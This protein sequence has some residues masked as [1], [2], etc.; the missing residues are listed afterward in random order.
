M[1]MANSRIAQ[2]PQLLKLI[3]AASLMFL[4]S[5]WLY[6]DGLAVAVLRWERQ[7]EYSHGYL[8]PLISLYF[9]WEA[10]YKILST[11]EKPSWLG[12]PIIVLALV[13][14]FV[15][16]VS[17]LFI[18]IHYSFI[19][20]LLGG[21]LALLGHAAK[22]TVLP[23][24]FLCFAIPLPYFLEVIL[25]AK[26]QLIS[27]ELGVMIIR[28]FSIPVF[29]SGNIIDLGVYK[30]QVVEA[31]S[32]LRY[33]F[34]LMSLSFMAAYFYRVRF[35][36]R[37]LLF[38]S[39]VPVTVVMNSVRIAITG[40]L[41]DQFGIEMAEGFLHDFE[42]WIIF[43]ACGGILVC[44]V[45]ILEML[46]SK[47]S[48][49]EVFAPEVEISEPSSAWYS[50]AGLRLAPILTG[51]V[52]VLVALGTI[53]QVDNRA[54]TPPAARSLASFPLK[55]DGWLGHHNKLDQPV[56]ESLK[57]TDYVLA[58]YRSEGSSPVN[59]YVAYYASQRKGSS[60]HSPRVC[61]PGGGWEIANL[62]RQNIQGFP[63]N[64]VIIR[65]E[66][67]SQLVYYWFEERGIPVANEYVK[68][69][70]LFRDAFQINRTDGALVR[71]TTPIFETESLADAENR[72]QNFIKS[73]RP[74]LLEFLPGPSMEK[75]G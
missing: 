54:E 39:A 31:C 8:I 66:L 70:M 10:R 53:S 15:G 33:L 18:L 42:G 41:V 23:I 73:A 44:E 13:I 47:I 38:I 61:I 36:K 56:I 28:W 68:K 69:W 25:T 40:I 24:L 62:E 26:M 74:K 1:E 11:Y 45:I 63:V 20:L 37:G 48:L 19:L 7:E 30:L 60:P 34:P 52:L 5:L 72:A 59:F 50:T 21:S 55:V 27:S 67:S 35:W 49:S 22:F 57:M 29:L 12:L 16:E 14:F 58:D 3:I 51:L 9:I 32:G 65:K 64:R 46:T 71:V 17:A 4:L 6:W 75:E 2:S 43:M